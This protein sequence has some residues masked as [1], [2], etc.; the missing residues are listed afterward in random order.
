MRWFVQSPEPAP[1]SRID[2]PGRTWK[3]WRTLSARQRNLMGEV[4]GCASQYPSRVRS[5]AARLDSRDMKQWKRST[6]ALRAWLKSNNAGW[7]EQTGGVRFGSVTQTARDG[8]HFG[9]E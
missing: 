2:S 5:I 3:A 4:P 9:L 1:I 7:E 6:T 8:S